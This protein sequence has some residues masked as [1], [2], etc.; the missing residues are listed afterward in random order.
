M[1]WESRGQAWTVLMA[2]H[3]SM[4]ETALAIGHARSHSNGLVVPSVSTRMLGL[5][6]PSQVT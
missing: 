1:G 5:S 6:R 4:G 3:I 2:E